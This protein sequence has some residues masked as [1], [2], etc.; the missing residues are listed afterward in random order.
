MGRA[1]CA[2]HVPEPAAGHRGRGRRVVPPLGVCSWHGMPARRASRAGPL[3]LLHAIDVIE[4]T[5]DHGGR[6]GGKTLERSIV[7]G[8]AVILKQAQRLLVGGSLLVDEQPIKILALRRLE[9]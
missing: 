9:G 3:S 8:A 6:F 1:K 5:L 7:P 4:V 2:R